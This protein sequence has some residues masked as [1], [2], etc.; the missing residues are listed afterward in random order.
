[1][2][3]KRGMGEQRHSIEHH[4]AAAKDGLSGR[5]IMAGWVGSG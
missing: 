2:S 1:M 5:H 3:E 4:R